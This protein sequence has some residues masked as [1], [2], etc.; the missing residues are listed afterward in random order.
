LTGLGECVA[1][2]DPEEWRELLDGAF[3][4]DAGQVKGK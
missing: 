4:V 3:E 2:D 1:R